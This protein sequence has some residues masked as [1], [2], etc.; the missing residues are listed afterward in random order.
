MHRTASHNKF[1]LAQN[2][3]SAKVKK[4]WSRGMIWV[5]LSIKGWKSVTAP[6]CIIELFFPSCHTEHA[7]QKIKGRTY[8]L[9]RMIKKKIKHNLDR[10]W[11]K[12][13]LFCKCTQP[14][15]LALAWK[16]R[17]G[18]HWLAETLEAASPAVLCLWLR[19]SWLPGQAPV[20]SVCMSLSVCTVPLPVPAFRTRVI[21]QVGL[22]VLDP[23]PANVSGGKVKWHFHFLNLPI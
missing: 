11:G 22:K 4:P 15:A 9:T 16:M 23:M 3:N 19:I 12:Q 14:H 20:Y 5:H 7:N 21:L 1:C 2:I 13:K 6:S 18:L 17:T 10:P 8:S